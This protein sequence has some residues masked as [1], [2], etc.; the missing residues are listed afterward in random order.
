MSDGRGAPLL[1]VRGLAKSFGGVQ[2]LA[3]IDFDLHAGELLALIG[4]NGAG[5][6]T[7]FNLIDG[8]LRADAGGVLLRGEPIQGLGPRAIWARGVG[9][10]FQVATPFLSMSV[11]Q[12]VQ[13]ALLAHRRR[14]FDPWRPLRAALRA[15]AQAL[16]VAVGLGA[17]ADEPCAALAYGELKALDLALA[18]AHEPSLLLMDEPT[19]G[20]APAERGALMGV[21]ARL[22][23]ERAVGV[24]FTEHSMDVVFGHADRVLVL[25]RGRRIAEGPPAEVR[26]DERVREAYLGRADAFAPGAA[27]PA[28]PEPGR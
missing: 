13:C 5:K 15:E 16:L 8:Q 20:M 26:A 11:A 18:L 1:Q 9:R 2:A 14:L 3:G 4:P 6:S 12:G 22:A 10:T 24:L 7:C 17:R 23:R 27:R 25:A 19:A 28:P 21:V